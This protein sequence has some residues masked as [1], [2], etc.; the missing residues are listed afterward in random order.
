MKKAESSSDRRTLWNGVVKNVA[1]FPIGSVLFP[2]PVFGKDF[3][4]VELSGP[5]GV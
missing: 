4:S 5:K 1:G 3:A 2:G